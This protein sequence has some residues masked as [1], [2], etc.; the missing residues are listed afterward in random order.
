MR[1]SGA[2]REREREG[3]TVENVH[4]KVSFEIFVD[5]TIQ[6]AEG[7]QTSD[8]HPNDEILVFEVC[9]RANTRSIR[10][11]VLELVLYI[12]RPCNALLAQIHVS[13]RV[14]QHERIVEH[15]VGNQSARK[16]EEAR[17]VTFGI[18]C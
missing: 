1:A 10:W 13:F 4:R 8:A 14:A 12:S 2:E 11:W 3:R 5:D 7:G 9:D 15:G 18:V 6:L 16:E 17:V